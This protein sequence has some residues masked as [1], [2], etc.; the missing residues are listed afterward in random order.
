MYFMMS[1]GRGFSQHCDKRLLYDGDCMTVRFISA[2]FC[3]LFLNTTSAAVFADGIHPGAYESS[4]ILDSL[5]RSGDNGGYNYQDFD[6]TK[7]LERFSSDGRY[8]DIFERAKASV[9]PIMAMSKE[10]V[11]GLI[12]PADTIR[13][14]MV[15]RSGC[16]VHGGG[17]AVYE[18]FGRSIDLEHPHT[19]YC[20]IGGECYPNKDFP[21][22]GS[23]WLD[24]RPESPTKGQ[25]FYF[26]GWFQHWFLRYIGILLKTMAQLWLISGD[27]SYRVQALTLLERFAEVYPD[28]DAKDLTYSGDDWDVYV[29]MTG[30]YWEGS[31]LYDIA[32]AVEILHN[33]IPA[34]LLETI[35]ENVYR[36]AFEAY[37]AKPAASNWGNNWN[38]PLAKFAT[39]LGDKEML[40]FM[41][42]G[43][44]AAQAP[45]LDNQFF[46]DGFPYEASLS[47]A[48]TYHGVAIGVADAMNEHGK[49]VW[50]HPHM[51]ESWNSFADLVCLDRYT[52]FAADMGSLNNKGW[53]LPVYIVEP[54]YRAYH[55]PVLARYLLQSMEING[56]KGPDSLDDLF[57]AP[58]DIVELKSMAECAPDLKSTVGAVRGIGI[59]RSGMGNNRTAFVMDYGYAHRAHS[60][61][62]RLNINFFSKG[63]EFI[64]EMGYPEYMD[65]TAPATGGWTTNTVCHS[66]VEVDEKRQVTGVFGDLTAFAT[67]KGFAFMEANCPD[68]Y[69][70]RNVS[71]YRRSAALID[72]PGGAYVLDIFRVSG[73]GRHDFLFHGPP[74]D[75]SFEGIEMP[76]PQEGTLA[77]KDVAFGE[78]AP[79]T[80]PYSLKNSGY[81]YLYNVRKKD[82][83]T[84]YTAMWRT[85]N[86]QIFR[87]H[88]LPIGSET[89]I[90]TEG[91]PRPSSK[92]LPPMPF[93]I[94]RR[95]DARN[96][97][98]STFVTALSVDKNERLIEHIERIELS[99]ESHRSAV[100]IKVTHAYGEDILLSTSESGA[101]LKSKD[102]RYELRGRCGLIT[103]RTDSQET[104]SLIEGTLLRDGN[105]TVTLDTPSYQARITDVHE[106]RLILD[107]EIMGTGMTSYA[108][109]DRGNVRSVYRIGPNRDNSID[110]TPAPWIGKGIIGSIDHARNTI[111]DSRPVYPLGEV[112][113]GERNYY[114]GAWITTLDGSTYHRLNCGDNEGFVLDS[115]T[116]TG[117]PYAFKVGEPFLLYDCGPGDTVTIT[118]TRQSKI[119]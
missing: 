40:D 51:R 108:F 52:H 95:D 103:K 30:S 15:N 33:N 59:L 60:H 9:A 29:K 48:S 37:R 111:I 45:V 5:N 83:S 72:V 65:D 23:G 70:H 113:S 27:D 74:V 101:T 110:I 20:P 22:D 87:A 24:T 41:L 38:P 82:I 12:L 100:A 76:S 54:A 75:V 4:S 28:L 69:V 104:M 105:Q 8:I 53:T 119:P 18:P 58:L 88:F 57:V 67:L 109:V 56:V 85:E 66:T 47:Y 26:K 71:E 93:L 11:R 36:A 112:R 17:T 42:N 39:V 78:K 96:K 19:V 43:H 35:H 118:R 107:R 92:S 117:V 64:P 84:P 1:A 16:P 98:Y 81:Q 62:D 73:G 7:L 79:E 44:P 114:D 68:A 3:A 99:P 80:H 14:F 55:T 25:R 116:G 10:E 97:G 46:R 106:D 31:V 91:Y 86:N 13:A 49:W 102:G 6:R 90:Q 61:A 34:P 50:N 77:G 32:S 2:L 89:F 94:R 115:A 21:D 63:R